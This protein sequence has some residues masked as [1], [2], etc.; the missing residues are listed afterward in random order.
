MATQHHPLGS[1]VP[2]LPTTV[3]SLAYIKDL[4]RYKTEV[5]YRWRGPLSAEK[6]HLRSNIELENRSGIAVKD[7]S[8]L[9]GSR[10]LS[11]DQNGFEILQYRHDYSD[12]LLERQEYLQQYLGS[13]A[14]VLKRR[15]DA[16]LAI[17]FQYT[18][19]RVTKPELGEIGRN[20]YEERAPGTSSSPG[21]PAYQV[22]AD[23]N[24]E[25][26]A[27][28][29]KQFLTPEELAKYPASHSWKPLFA[30]V[31]N[32]PLAFCDPATLSL[33]DIIEVDTPSA[34]GMSK[35]S[36]IKYNAGQ[37]WY[38]C[39]DQTP[40]Q[41]SFFKIWDS[42]MTACAP[43]VPHGALRFSIDDSIEVVRDSI[44]TRMIVVVHKSKLKGPLSH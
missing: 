28:I 1:I 12:E 4:E 14:G 16:D 17:C 2:E 35:T 29:I 36:Y 44:E 30:P 39:R 26:P 18:F 11:L 41:V 38:W 23:Y 25:F 3:A 20:L 24:K 8:D 31:R 42:D 27:Q 37:Q 9:I 13:I 34:T 10:Y 21:P 32:A 5:P 43:F 19:R 15:L 33:D 7:V 6:S 22:H 40:E